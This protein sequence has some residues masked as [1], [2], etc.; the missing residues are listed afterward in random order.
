MSLPLPTNDEYVPETE[1]VSLPSVQMA[2]LAGT[3]LPMPCSW[4]DSPTET[5]GPCYVSVH[6]TDQEGE[7]EGQMEGEM[8]KRKRERKHESTMLLMPFSWWDSPTETHE[9]CYVSVALRP[10]DN[11]CVIG[12]VMGERVKEREKERREIFPYCVA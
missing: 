6:E 9:L 2:E 7:R 11:L 10:F 5:H 4:W 8:R 12:M 3:M 1:Y